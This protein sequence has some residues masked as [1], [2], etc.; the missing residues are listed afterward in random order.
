MFPRRNTES[1]HPKTST[2][3]DAKEMSA[4]LT[5]VAVGQPA[6]YLREIPFKREEAVTGTLRLLFAP[7]SPHNSPPA[8]H[9]RCSQL[10]PAVRSLPSLHSP[11]PKHPRCTPPHTTL[12]GPGS[13]PLRDGV[14]MGHRDKRGEKHTCPQ[15]TLA[16]VSQKAPAC[17]PLATPRGWSHPGGLAVGL[18]GPFPSRWRGLRYHCSHS[19]EKEKK[20]S[21]I[22]VLPI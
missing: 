11:G 8:G 9:S 13:C 16:G 2:R 7:P 6:L 15:H 14:W 18:R 4:A 22:S 17:L 3:T 1:N 19:S 10:P 12:G 20:S 21:I 5:A